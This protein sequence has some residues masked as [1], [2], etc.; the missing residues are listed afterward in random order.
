MAL[1]ELGNSLVTLTSAG[2]AAFYIGPNIE[3]QSKKMH[4]WRHAG[5]LGA[6]QFAGFAPICIPQLF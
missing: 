4:C 2:V 3:A 6:I 1:M 5:F